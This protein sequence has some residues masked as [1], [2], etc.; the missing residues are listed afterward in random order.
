MV[1]IY[2]I[3]QNSGTAG[4][5]FLKIGNDARGSSLA[6]SILA[7]VSGVESIYWNPAGLIEINGKEL[8]V[9]YNKW[10]GDT[11]LASAAFGFPAIVGKLGKLAGSITYF[12]SGKIGIEEKNILADEYYATFSS[13]GYGMKLSRIKLGVVLKYT[14]ANSFGFASHSTFVDLGFQSELINNL[15]IGFVL[16]NA[17][18]ILSAE[19]SKD[20]I[21]M[22]YELGFAYIYK[23]KEKNLIKLFLSPKGA[24]DESISLKSGVEFNYKDTIYLRVG[25]DLNGNDN[26]S[27]MKGLNLGVG[28]N[29]GSFDI[30]LAWL[31]Y[32]ELGNVL[33]TS[34]KYTF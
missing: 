16:R 15:F 3:S 28:A 25:Y 17:G 10:W 26:L 31:F 6:G 9:S 12:G 27:F 34:I 14:Y 18:F 33:Q 19:G 29:F 8:F 7:D 13:I 1:R 23:L 21:P 4:L 20:K 22:I 30:N 2:G 32:A 11:F 5:Q 24:L